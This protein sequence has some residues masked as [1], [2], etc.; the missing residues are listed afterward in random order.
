MHANLAAILRSKV[1]EVSLRRALILKAAE[2]FIKVTAILMQIS[3]SHIIS[4]KVA[5]YSACSLT[6]GDYIK[7]FLEKLTHENK[8]IATLKKWRYSQFFFHI[9]KAAL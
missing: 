4:F 3:F 6:N 8:V 9:V 1:L 5:S 7:Y 2:T